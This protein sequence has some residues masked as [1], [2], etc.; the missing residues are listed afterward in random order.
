MKRIISILLITVL[1]LSCLPLSGCG[2]AALKFYTEK[3]FFD[4]I[5]DIKNELKFQFDDKLLN[6][7]FLNAGSSEN[8]VCCVDSRSIREGKTVEIPAEHD[9]KKVI[10]VVSNPKI[11]QKLNGGIPDSVKFIIGC[12]FD[13]QD[14]KFN[15][16]KDLVCIYD[17]FYKC[18]NIKELEFEGTVRLIEKSFEQAGVERIT[19]SNDV[20]SSIETSVENNG[21]AKTTTEV[22]GGINESF[23]SCENLENVVFSKGVNNIENSF[24]ECNKLNK[25]EFDGQVKMVVDS[26]NDCK[27]IESVEIKDSASDIHNSFTDYYL[28]N[29]D[30]NDA[31]TKKVEAAQN[32]CNTDSTIPKNPKIMIVT[33]KDNDYDYYYPFEACV[34]LPYAA[35]NRE[36]ANLLVRIDEETSTRGYWVEKP[37][38][39][40]VKDAIGR[41]FSFSITRLDNGSPLDT[42]NADSTYYLEVDYTD[43]ENVIPLSYSEVM[44]AL[45]DYLNTVLK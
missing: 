3:E 2:S 36:E 8:Y 41:Q 23:L 38:N 16:P 12:K 42:K 4:S 40:V 19:F 34:A 31:M 5:K 24:N 32:S 33:V 15:I 17:S 6:D 10:G 44:N 26:F 39:K 11:L 1:L 9:G 35:T 30:L 22:N 20:G 43:N 45:K 18:E 28:Y 27:A 7:N 13:P 37:R 29:S 14:D 21:A 25:V